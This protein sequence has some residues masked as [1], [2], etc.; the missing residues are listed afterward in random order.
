VKVLLSWLREFCPTDLSAE[1]LAEKLTAQGAKVES[2]IRPWE[3][4]NG[5]VVARVLEVRDHPHSDK[6]CLAR[7]EYGSGQRELVVGVRNMM[8]GDLV[9]LAGP[10]AR[11][12]GLPEPLSARMIRGVVS[13]G[14]LC[15]ARELGISGDHTGILVLPPESPLGA[16]FKQTFGLD[17]AVLDVEVK[18]N[19]PDL[20]SVVGVA[21][22]ASAATGL[23]LVQ[24]DASATESEEKAEEAATVEILDLERCPR[25]LAKVIRGVNPGA[26]PLRVQ[27]RLTAM[28]MRPLSNVVDA[29]NY[30]ML[31]S[32]Q[33]LHPFD[34]ALLEGAGVVVRRAA[35][36]ERLVALDDVERVLTAEDLLIA[37]RAKG[38]AIAGIFGSASAEVSDKTSDVLLESAHFQPQGILRTARRLGLRTEASTRFERGTDPEAVDEAADRAA[39]L[40]AKWAGGTVLAGSVEVGGPPE[41]RRVGMRP[42]RASMVL[43]YPVSSSEAAHALLRLGMHVRAARDSVKAVI[44]SYRWDLHIEED[45]IEE[46]A[47]VQGYDRVPETMPAVRQPGAVPPGYALRRRVREA[48]G[49]AGLREAWTYSFA[50]LADLRLMGQDASTAVRVANPL[51]ADQEFLRTSLVPGLLKAVLHNTSRQVPGVW[52]FDVGRVFAPGDPVQE[53][54]V[55]A[56]VLAGRF[57]SGYPGETRGLDFFDAKGAVETLLRALGVTD[58]SLR[59]AAPPPFHPARSGVVHAGGRPAG[60]VGELHPRV[61]EQMDLPPRTAV[62]EVDVADLAAAAAPTF[63]FGEPPRLPPVHRDLAFVVDAATPAADVRKAMIEAGGELVAAVVLFDV[64]EGGPIPEGKK[65]LAF[66]VDFRAPDRTLTDDEAEQAVRKIVDRLAEDFQA[67][68]RA[69]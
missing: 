48:L 66:S 22:E 53:R 45:L 54:E 14:M 39:S 52:L 49:R 31:E 69:G 7:V 3:R 44:P 15:S 59:R 5:V 13:E 50:S 27:A 2:V 26:S 67:E 38:I 25:Y 62:A 6:L 46:V 18:S 47:R 41:R 60:V 40:I 21:R 33:P 65:S 17:D 56:F 23:P 9:P 10:G 34:L 8:A 51:G 68:L 37:D 36:G 28:G 4:L 42:S 64:F 43:G 20:L 61:T 58:W 19:R 11:V 29:T 35:E 24:R 63:A 16:D 55:A 12:P 32:G 30:V 1:E 57:S